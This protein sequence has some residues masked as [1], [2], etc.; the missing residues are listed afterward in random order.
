MSPPTRTNLRKVQPF[1]LPHGIGQALEAT[2]R[3]MA[4]P[5]MPHVSLAAAA[6]GLIDKGL[7]S[8]DALLQSGREVVWEAVDPP[9]GARRREAASSSD[10]RVRDDTYVQVSPLALSEEIIERLEDVRRRLSAATGA[11]VSTVKALRESL[12][13][14]LAA[15]EQA[16]A[17]VEA[18]LQKYAREF[19]A[20]GF[21]SAAQVTVV[22]SG[23]TQ[24]YAQ[25]AGKA[26][27]WGRPTRAASKRKATPAPKVA[28]RSTTTARP[29]SRGHHQQA[30]VRKVPSGDDDDGGGDG[31]PPP[32]RRPPAEAPT[33]ETAGIASS[34]S[35]ARESRPPDPAWRAKAQSALARLFLAAVS[36]PQQRPLRGP[37]TPDRGDR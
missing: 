18:L 20:L 19:G 33:T 22:A 14:G 35:P 31:E 2:A 9:R 6:R 8:L 36:R 15:R 32:A 3:A 17:G 26:N 23:V 30:A 28:T 4:S 12:V 27:P 5:M 13:R 10:A 25:P 11:K 34:T 21:G 16:H 29:R 24:R 1:L 37:V 7:V